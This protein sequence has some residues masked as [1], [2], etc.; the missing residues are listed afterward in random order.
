MTSTWHI[1]LSLTFMITTLPFEIAVLFYQVLAA[2]G[3]TGASLRALSVVTAFV[4]ITMLN[5]AVNVWICM[6]ISRSF[7]SDVIKVLTLKF[8]DISE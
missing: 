3:D 6:A 4:P 1:A 5:H 7:R 8:K 2:E